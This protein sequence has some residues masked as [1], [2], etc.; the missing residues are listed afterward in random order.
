MIK[1]VLLLISV[2]LISLVYVTFKKD[3]KVDNIPL[4]KETTST[5]KREQIEPIQN[6]KTILIDKPK[7]E[8]SK[9][10]IIENIKVDTHNL[11]DTKDIGKG[12]TIEYIES[13]DISRDQKEILIA[14]IV[15]Q[16]S[17]Q[18]ENENE[19][20]PMTH[21]QALELIENDVKNGILP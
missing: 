7:E 11:G 10:I 5:S 6:T 8:V 3:Q 4:T 14:D 12:L 20:L 15:Y 16:E 13:L 1:G 19:I 18:K 17:L 2:I 9:K 21:S